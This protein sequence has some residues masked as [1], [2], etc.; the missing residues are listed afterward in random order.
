M[1][2]AEFLE[3]HRDAAELIQRGRKIAVKYRQVVKLGPLT[4]D[5][6]AYGLLPNG[7]EVELM[8]PYVDEWLRSP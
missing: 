5:H 6:R 3:K 4:F 2:R 1:T 8:A 7:G